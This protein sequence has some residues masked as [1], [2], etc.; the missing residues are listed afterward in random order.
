M[1]Q[2]YGAATLAFADIVLEG[3]RPAAESVQII[4]RRLREHEALDGTGS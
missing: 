2:R 1:Y 4:L 3:E